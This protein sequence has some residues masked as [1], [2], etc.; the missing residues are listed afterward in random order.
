MASKSDKLKSGVNRASKGLFAGMTRLDE[1]ETKSVNKIKEDKKEQV[2]EKETIKDKKADDIKESAKAMPEPVSTVVEAEREDLAENNVVK[3]EVKSTPEP[4]VVQQENSSQPEVYVQQ[5]QSIA[6]SPQVEAEAISSVPLQE[7]PVIQPQPVVRETIVQPQYQPQPQIQPQPYMQPQI[8]PQ[9]YQQP[10]YATYQQPIN[11]MPQVAYQEPV[12]APMNA[13]VVKE[14][15]SATKAEKTEKNSRYEKDKFLLLDIRGLR[16]YV[17]H[18]AKASNMSATKYIRNL[19]EK[20]WAVNNDI[21]Q[22]HKALEERLKER[23]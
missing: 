22:A 20:D 10:V 11:Q 1:K 9:S 7:A 23:H 18:M 5:P 4:K 16:D 17:E 8:Q 2:P 12:N 6:Q 15:K 3:E 14:S 21:Y 19:I 13:P